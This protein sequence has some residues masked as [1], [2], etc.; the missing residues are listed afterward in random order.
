MAHV[1]ERGGRILSSKVHVCSFLEDWF[2]GGGG[3]ATLFYVCVST[4]VMLMLFGMFGFPSLSLL[5][6]AR[7]VKRYDLCCG[8]GTPYSPRSHHAS[9]SISVASFKPP[10][11]HRLLSSPARSSS[12]FPSP[13]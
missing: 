1:R 8:I 2:I 5:P 9:F 12:N 6:S 10:Y 11:N 13:D 3:A 7:E 4:H